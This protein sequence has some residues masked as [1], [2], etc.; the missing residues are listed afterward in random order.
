LKQIDIPVYSF[1]G[2][3]GSGKTT[4]IEKL[5]PELKRRGI[6][7]GVIKHDAHDFEIDKEGKDSWRFSN[8]G[9]D[10]VEISSAEKTAIISK[11]NKAMHL[12]EIISRMG[13]VDLIITEGY[14]AGDKPKIAIYRAASGK[15]LPLEPEKLTAIVTD[16]DTK[17]DIPCFG[18]EDVEKVVDFI[19]CRENLA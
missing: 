13:N 4:F 2:F 18:L 7:L 9:A 8:A 16:V 6:R 15:P 1:I 10:V 14:K 11:T 17:T 5:I 12:D 19:L 3:S